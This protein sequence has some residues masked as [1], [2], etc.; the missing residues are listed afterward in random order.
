MALDVKKAV[1][2]A[3]TYLS[4]LLQVESSVMLL[5]EV[6]QTGP[7]WE[8][9]LSYPEPGSPTIRNMFGGRTY[10]VVRIDLETGEFVSVKI[11]TVAY[12]RS[13]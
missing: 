4:D 7:Y 2:L 9:T 8:I 12:D 3:K 1:E 6:E 11:R 13:A 10:K 5:E